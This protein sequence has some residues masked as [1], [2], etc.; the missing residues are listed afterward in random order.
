[1]AKK[2]TRIKSSTFAVR[3]QAREEVETAIKQIGDLQR[4]LQRLATQQ[5]DELAAITEKICPAI[6]CDSRRN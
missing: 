3:Y 5:N 6:A 2:A 1:M 4:E